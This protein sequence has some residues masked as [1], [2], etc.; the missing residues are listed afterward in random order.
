M[1]WPA[2]STRPAVGR[3]L[4]V[5]SSKSVVLPEPFGP[6]TPTIAGA[7]TLNSAS[8]VKVGVRSRMPRV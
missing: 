7:S 5:T 1:S 4:P 8:S 2:H 3:L 6:S